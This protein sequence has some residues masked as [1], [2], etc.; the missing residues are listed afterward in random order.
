MKKK[1]YDYDRYEAEAPRV[2]E[3]YAIG[4]IDGRY[5]LALGG[6]VIQRLEARSEDGAHR[7]GMLFIKSIDF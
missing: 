3:P 5:V 4:K 1:A 7:E 2:P 6:K